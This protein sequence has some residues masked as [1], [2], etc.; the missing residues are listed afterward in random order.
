MNTGVSGDCQ[1]GVTCNA[2]QLSIPAVVDDTMVAY[3]GRV[4]AGTDRGAAS[5]PLSL[6]LLMQHY[7][8][9]AWS[10]NKAD[11]CSTLSLANDGVLFTDDTQHYDVAS[12]DLVLGTATRITVGLGAPS[13]GAVVGKADKGELLFNFGAPQFAV[14]VP[15]H[16]VL[17]KQPQQPRWLADPGNPN[18]LLGE[19][20]FG[21]SRGNDR[22]IYRREVMH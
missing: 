16:I 22:I 6:S 2:K 4:L 15:Y 5:E 9:G 14:R 7:Q 1:V 21:S 10:S 8:N 20:I 12:G 3:Y 18:S 13:P 19:A 17:E 11:V